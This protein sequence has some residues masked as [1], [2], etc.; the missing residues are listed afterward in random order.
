MKKTVKILTFVVAVVTLLTVCVSF[1]SAVDAPEK[2]DVVSARAN[3]TTAILSWDEC[4]G[5]T[6]YRVFQAV[7]GKWKKLAD[8]GSTSYAVNK[9][10]PDTYY[11]FAVRP[12]IIKDGAV[13]W[14]KSYTVA[15]IRTEA[16][17]VLELEI[18]AYSDIAYLYWNESE[19]AD[20]YRVYQKI[21]GKWKAL[22]T[23]RET[24]YT[25][26]NLNAST[27][28]QFCVKSYMRNGSTVYWNSYYSSAKVKTE[29]PTDIYLRSSVVNDKVT[30]T[31]NISSGATGYRVFKQQSG[32]WVKVKDV[33]RR[34]TSYTISGLDA[35]TKYTFTVRPYAKTDTGAVWGPLPESVTVRTDNYDNI[36]NIE[37][38]T[39]TA[40][41]ITLKWN[42]VMD[43][44]GYRVFERTS[45]GWKKIKDV[46]ITSYTVTGLK[47]DKT[48]R[49]AVRAYYDK[50]GGGIGWYK[51]GRTV[52]VATEPTEAD[53]IEGRYKKTLAQLTSGKCYFDMDNTTYLDDSVYVAS[54]VVVANRNG[55]YYV[56]ETAEGYTWDIIYREKY[57][58]AYMV[59]DSVKSYTIIPGYNREYFKFVMESIGF[60]EHNY[61]IDVSFAEWNGKKVVCE[62][63]YDEEYE[64]YYDFYYSGGQLVGS[65]IDYGEDFIDVFNVVTY[66]DSPA[67]SLFVVPSGYKYVKTEI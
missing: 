64:T 30:L 62:S 12:Y 7:S 22:K 67:S 46:T 59:I 19:N 11:K 10:K 37:S 23:T 40:D 5:A 34:T 42:S 20:G 43:A 4:E 48:Y 31:W 39:S 58:R 55:D 51:L 41:S 38:A 13:T 36:V 6:G 17:D 29:K 21:D 61:T 26:K 33:S 57:Q 65:V 18:D 9:L 56:E 60:F 50:N 63:F 28:Y 54:P 44:S 66:S 24:T 16:K 45:A 8:I 25:V 3:S 52:S 32:K 49:F 53:L 1:A 27:N 2:P 15:G 35:Y 47:S 14:S